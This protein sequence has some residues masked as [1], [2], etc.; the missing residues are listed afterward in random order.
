MIA[1]IAFALILM[2]ACGLTW[3]FTW[4]RTRRN[5][6]IRAVVALKATSERIN[7]LWQQHS[8]ELEAENAK[9]KSSLLL[10]AEEKT[11]LREQAERE[12]MSG[13]CADEAEGWV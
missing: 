4:S 13:S 7:A 6:E 9:L 11:K 10:S 8:E 12:A 5:A 3:W 1:A 2:V